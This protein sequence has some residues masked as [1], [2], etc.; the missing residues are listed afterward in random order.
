MDSV[1]GIT[2]KPQGQFTADIEA[3]HREMVS[4]FA[5]SATAAYFHRGRAIGIWKAQPYMMRW[6]KLHL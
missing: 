4:E 3:A 6:P 1:C 2:A 5:L